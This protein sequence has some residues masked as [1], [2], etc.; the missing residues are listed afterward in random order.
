MVVDRCLFDSRRSICYS[1]HEG[2]V[3]E[4]VADGGENGTDK[5]GI[6]VDNDAEDTAWSEEEAEG[7]T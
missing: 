1:I 2:R 6:H 5:D 4:S 7:V 3:T